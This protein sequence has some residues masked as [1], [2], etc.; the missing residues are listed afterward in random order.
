MISGQVK[1]FPKFKYTVASEVPF[2]FDFTTIAPFIKHNNCGINFCLLKT[3]MRYA[4]PFTVKYSFPQQSLFPLSKSIKQTKIKLQYVLTLDTPS[5]KVKKNKIKDLLKKKQNPVT[6]IFTINP[7]IIIIIILSCMIMLFN[8]LY[9][10]VLLQ[11]SIQK[12][13]QILLQH[14]LTRLVL[15]KIKHIKSF[16]DFFLLPT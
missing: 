4:Y 16:K 3:D 6:E 11:Q 5:I 8:L 7:L 13:I 14:Q 2:V 1:C 10:T 9:C 15:C 12:K